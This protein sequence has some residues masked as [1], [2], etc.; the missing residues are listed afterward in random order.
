MRNRPAIK[1]F[2]VIQDRLD[3]IRILYAG[4]P[5][6]EPDFDYYRKE[7]AGRCGPDL[8]VEFIETDTFEHPPGTKFRLILSKVSDDPGS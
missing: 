2:Q 6:A 1:K 4:E 5:G 3:A 8:G 7:I